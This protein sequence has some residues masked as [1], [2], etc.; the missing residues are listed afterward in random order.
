MDVLVAVSVRGR[1]T[2]LASEPAELCSSLL[3][4]LRGVYGAPCPGFSE[5]SRAEEER[6]VA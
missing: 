1:P 5:S 2:D 6:P 4:Q 3:D